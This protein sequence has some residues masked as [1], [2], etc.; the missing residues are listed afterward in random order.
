MD[1]NDV[2]TVE[3]QT[4]YWK[5][6]EERVEQDNEWGEQNHSNEKWL[7][8]LTEEIGEAAEAAL[9]L[10]WA[11]A[12]NR[13]GAKPPYDIPAYKQLLKDEIIDSMAVLM[14]WHECI[15]RQDEWE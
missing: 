6:L 10:G 15:D 3:Q 1:K 11:R 2:P 14:A 13:D 7:T 5:V 12:G 9:K 8:I 4:I